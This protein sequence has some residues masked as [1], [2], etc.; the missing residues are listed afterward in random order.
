MTLNTNN[1]TTENNEIFIRSDTQNEEGPTTDNDSIY[2]LS[3][4][5]TLDNVAKTDRTEYMRI[6]MRTYRK[7]H[8]KSYLGAPINCEIC[9]KLTSR[10][11]L[12]RH[13]KSILCQRVKEIKGII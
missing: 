1:T 13:Q 9:D 11:K 7:T 3:T 5:A 6:Y 10:V 4:A 12:S 2:S 8:Y